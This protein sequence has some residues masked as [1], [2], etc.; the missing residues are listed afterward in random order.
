MVGIARST[1][2]SGGGWPL[3]FLKQ[4]SGCNYPGWSL[5]RSEEVFYPTCD[6]YQITNTIHKPP[7]STS[8]LLALALTET[9]TASPFI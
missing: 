3:V 1:V 7:M 4:C 9:F 5:V 6:K 2:I 8:V